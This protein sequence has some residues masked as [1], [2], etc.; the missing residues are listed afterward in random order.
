VSSAIR[1]RLDLF[2]ADLDISIGFY[3]RFL[4]FELQRRHVD[5]AQPA[6]R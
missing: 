2:G 1:L 3:E 4:G 6:R 5:Y